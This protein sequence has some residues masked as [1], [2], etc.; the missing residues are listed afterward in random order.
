[1][2]DRS[3]LAWPFFTKSHWETQEQVLKL[4]REHEHLDGAQEKDVRH[5]LITQG[6][7]TLLSPCRD[8]APVRFPYSVLKN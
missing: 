4:I 1:M 7:P 8:L 3:F 6:S 2:P 5:W